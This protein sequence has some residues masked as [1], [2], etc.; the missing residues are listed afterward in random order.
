MPLLITFILG[1]FF[2]VG[3]LIVKESKN[4]ESVEH[5][6]VALGFGAMIGLAV[7]DLIPETLEGRE[8]LHIIYLI[9][10]VVLGILLLVFL[11]RFIP[12]HNHSHEDETEE[13]LIHI[14]L[15]S[16]IAIMLHNIVEG[17][18]VYTIA[19]QSL[20][21]GISM[22]VGVG[23]HNIP[24]GMLIYSTLQSENRKKRHGILF[25]AGISTF[26]GGLI[27]WM[28]S[29]NVPESVVSALIAVALGMVLY[30]LLF[31][32]LPSVI[33]SKTRKVSIIGTLIGLALVFGSIMI[34]D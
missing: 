9:G 34:F 8:N 24:M 4:K 6:S 14:G 12:E 15:I 31:E 17:M 28:F 13:N 32:L 29:S 33:H 27:M 23:L 25:G 10:F 11:D 26:V 20:A 21:S 18:G 1:A 7:F 3:V 16:A 22:M 2:A 19:S 5:W 30:I